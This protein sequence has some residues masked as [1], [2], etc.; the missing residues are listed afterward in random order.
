MGLRERKK[1]QTRLHISN[2]AT[3]LFLERGFANVT[4]AEVAEAAGISK[5]TVFNYFSTKEDLLL[6][7]QPQDVAALC[8]AITDRPPGQ[9]LTAALRALCLRWLNGFPLAT[10]GQGITKFWTEVRA[11][12]DLTNR[13]MQQRT[14]LQDALIA[15]LAR[16]LPDQWSAAATAR[17]IVA[18]LET[19]FTTVLDRHLSG[20]PAKRNLAQGVI[21]IND[22]FDLLANGLGD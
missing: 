10:N 9:S 16:D 5:M 8:A 1:E 15:A 19:V 13:L 4:V 22:A 12:Q 6:D 2:V 17:L 7:R 11:N 3:E 18:T 21:A 14:E 20:M